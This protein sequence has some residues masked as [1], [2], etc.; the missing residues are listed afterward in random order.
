[1]IRGE[2]S[3][4]LQ[5]LVDLRISGA[6]GKS[7]RIQ[8]TIDTGFNGFL[9]LPAS[10]IAELELP[11]LFRHNG[12]L[13][14]GTI[15]VFDVFEATVDWNGQWRVAEVESIDAV[16][17]LGMAIMEDHELSIVVRE[18]GIATIRQVN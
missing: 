1:M 13:A 9:T 8:L 4:S 18:H 10:V 15:Q 12:E 11:W 2:V 3:S 16:P 17:L 14:D 5:A 6:N 7:S